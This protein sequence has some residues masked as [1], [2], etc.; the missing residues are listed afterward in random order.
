MSHPFS[1]TYIAMAKAAEEI[2]AMRPDV[3]VFEI[4]DF[5]VTLTDFWEDNYGGEIK[6]ERY[7][8]NRNGWDV[9]RQIESAGNV[10]C[11]G[12]Y[13]RFEKE[14]DYQDKTHPA[15]ITGI[16]WAADLLDRRLVTWIPRLDQLLVM[17]GGPN[18]FRWEAIQAEDG[19]S[20]GWI[21]FK[22]CDV[23]DWHE[24]ALT[25]V[26]REKHGKTWRDGQWVKV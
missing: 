10:N 7:P 18:D 19:G 12:S 3:D 26:M 16:E 23:L 6:P 1:E 15:N 14:N 2:Q 9:G 11:V 4:G 20:T 21:H 5:F 25:V 8:K 22:D 17:L 24:L 13:L